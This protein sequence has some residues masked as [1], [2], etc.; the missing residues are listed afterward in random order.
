LREDGRDVALGRGRHGQ[1]RKDLLILDVTAALNPHPLH[2]EIEACGIVGG[3][4][5]VIDARAQKLASS[6]AQGS[7]GDLAAARGEG[8]RRRARAVRHPHDNGLS[9]SVLEELFDRVAQ[10]A[11][12]PQ[13]AEG[14]L[15]VSETFHAAGTIDGT[16][17]RAS[18]ERGARRVEARDMRVLTLF[19]SR[20]EP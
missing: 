17:K 13:T 2:R 11:R 9:A 18:D 4:A 6:R 7:E 15:E 8:Q 14:P 3:D 12:L 1:E 16:T 20:L 19:F 10:R 5:I